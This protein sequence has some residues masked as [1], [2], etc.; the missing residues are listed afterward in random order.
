MAAPKEPRIDKTYT[1]GSFKSSIKDLNAPLIYLVGGVGEPVG[2][3]TKFPGTYMW[4]TGEKTYTKGFSRC[5]DF[6]VYNITRVAIVAKD[7]TQKSPDTPSLNGSVAECKKILSD[8]GINP[9]KKIIVAFSKGCEIYRTIIDGFGG[10]NQFDKVLIGGIYSNKGVFPKVPN[11]N[12]DLKKYPNKAYY[13]GS[14]DKGK[15][16]GTSPEAW[17]TIISDVK[18]SQIFEKPYGNTAHNGLPNAMATWIL[19]NV[20]VNKT[21]QSSNPPQNLGTAGTFGTNGTDGTFGTNGTNGTD[22][23]QGGNDGGGGG[24]DGDTLQGTDGT[25]GTSGTSGEPVTSGNDCGDLTK[26]DAKAKA[27]ESPEGAPADVKSQDPLPPPKNAAPVSSDSKYNHRFYLVPLKD[28]QPMSLADMSRKDNKYHKRYWAWRPD[29]G[30]GFG[31]KKFEFDVSSDT[32]ISLIAGLCP[33]WPPPS[34]TDDVAPEPTINGIWKNLIN[35]QKS[36]ES[37]LD[38][39]I[40]LNC[41]D[42]GVYNNNIEYVFEAGNELHM[43]LLDKSFVTNKGSKLAIGTSVNTDIVD[44]NNK[45]SSWRHWPKWSGI[46]VDHCLKNCG[47]SLFSSGIETNID[48]YHQKILEKDKLIN[49]PGNKQWKWKELKS[50]GMQDNVFKPSKIWMDPTNLNSEELIKDS[51]DIAILIPDFHFTKDGQITEK[52]KKVIQQIIKLKWKLGVIS[53]VKHHTTQSSQ[54][55]AEVLVYMDE[56]GKFIT[57]GGNTTP[58][59]ADSSVS[60]GH[61][62]AVKD[63]T[64]KDFAQIANDT[65]VNGAIFISNVKGA[66]EGHREG[67]IDSKLYVTSIFKDYYERID[68]EPGKLTS[69]MYDILQP[70]M[71][72][73]PA[74]PAPVVE[75][76]SLKEK[77]A[78]E[79]PPD[80]IP[81][82]TAGAGDGTAILYDPKKAL[83]LGVLTTVPTKYR[84]NMPLPYVVTPAFASFV[85]M[86]DTATTTG[87]MKLLSQGGKPKSKGFPGDLIQATSLFRTQ[88][89]QVDTWLGGAKKYGIGGTYYPGEDPDGRFS[90]TGHTGKI[91]YPRGISDYPKK[92][93]SRPGGPHQGGRAVDLTGGGGG[94]T[95]GNKFDAAKVENYHQT[96]ASA[97]Q[98]WIRKNGP[99]FGWYNYWQEVWHF[100]YLLDQRTSNYSNMWK[101]K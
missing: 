92:G 35:G 65:W 71:S 80:P 99:S 57:I 84:A 97:A 36:I 73:K 91:A 52:G 13:F 98:L 26:L 72:L 59:G 15:G 50:A 44:K 88:K 94:Y 47:Y 66:P 64:L 34:K 60:Q 39:P 41:Y 54:L 1:Y 7:G 53:A 32:G 93:T 63:I 75:E 37:F 87:G 51:G 49:Y 9:S 77:V 69:R 5:A 8:N 6:N 74:N 31:D 18:P 29:E 82:P 48:L 62:I 79:T 17:A 22:G 19:E 28:N 30:R 11:V 96:T 76:P 89:A 23:T 3:P 24:Q 68:K 10:W 58:R 2:S 33:Y 61:H 43:T 81:T 86:L 83:Q 21:A 78:L 12:A 42:V 95:G 14:G 100:G 27:N 85:K 101:G 40:L 56:Y 25:S 70:Y 67:G 90:A 4:G 38:V 55:Y 46:W 20:S 45:D 16:D